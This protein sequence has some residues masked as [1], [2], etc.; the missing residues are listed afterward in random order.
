MRSRFNDPQ[1]RLQ[2]AMAAA[3]LGEWWTH[4]GEVI[5]FS[6]R[7][8]DIY[9][10]GADLDL[11]RGRV[12]A[13]IEPE[14]REST[15]E[16]VGQAIEAHA[17]FDVEYRVHRECDGRIVW[18]HGRGRG[19]YDGPGPVGLIGVIEDITSRRMRDEV[20]RLRLREIEH[21]DN[22]LFMLVRALV[23][24]IP[25]PTRED[26]IGAL[27]RR[28][29]ALALAHAVVIRGDIGGVDLMELAQAELAAYA[30]PGRCTVEGPAV[31]LTGEAAQSL[32]MMLHEL[33]TNAVKHGGLRAG[34]GR[35][36]IAWRLEPDGALFIAW[37]EQSDPALTVGE[38]PAGS[39]FG[40]ALL[41][42]LTTQLGG[43]LRRE[44][45]SDGLAIDLVIPRRHLLQVP[46]D[47]GAAWPL[48]A[49]D[50]AQP[51]PGRAEAYASATRSP[52]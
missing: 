28:L 52:T 8:G 7:A 37:R 50:P 27:D 31:R 20:E 9:G 36:R 11:T 48:P 29:S 42:R 22:N 17:D 41:G 33:A 15:L 2:L 35:L 19:V 12:D 45:A 6:R 16:A 24:L 34:S 26:Y 51:A 32:A 49:P 1:A 18:V 38:A 47:G 3:K 43:S 46:A 21:R 14:D 25:F 10:L 39:G 44:L 23:Q 30:S 13:M 4:G 5:H 40:S